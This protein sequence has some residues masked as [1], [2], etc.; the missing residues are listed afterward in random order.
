MHDEALPPGDR[1]TAG[2][3]FS[4]S[5]HTVE[6]LLFPLSS[7]YCREESDRER[8]ANNCQQAYRRVKVDLLLVGI[9]N[10]LGGSTSLRR[11][12]GFN[13]TATNFGGPTSPR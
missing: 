8:A 12:G 1:H 6:N 2:S 7:A 10:V 3:S 13:L 4:L 9:T 11:L 5:R